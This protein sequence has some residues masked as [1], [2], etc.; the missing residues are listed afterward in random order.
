MRWRAYLCRRIAVGKAPDDI[1][2]SRGALGR[3]YIVLQTLI[4]PIF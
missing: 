1:L 3:V 2:D 4:V